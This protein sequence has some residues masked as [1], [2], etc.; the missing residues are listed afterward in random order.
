MKTCV[1]ILTPHPVM[2]KKNFDQH[3]RRFVWGRFDRQ[4]W[5]RFGHTPGDVL[6]LGT[7]CLDTLAFTV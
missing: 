1:N 5:G 4:T 7:F 6:V 2:L 3:R